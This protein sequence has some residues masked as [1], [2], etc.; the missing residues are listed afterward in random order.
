MLKKKLSWFRERKEK[1]NG[2]MVKGFP[3]FSLFPV[4]RLSMYFP[5]GNSQIGLNLFY[6]QLFLYFNGA[7]KSV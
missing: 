2:K 4:L 1:E 3:F 5:H 6:F 7:T